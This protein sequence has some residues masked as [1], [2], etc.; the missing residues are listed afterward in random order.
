MNANRADLQRCA[1]KTV[2]GNPCRMRPLRGGR[3]CWTHDPEEATR[4]DAAR[5]R[6]GANRKRRG[7]VC[8]EFS[9][10]SIDGIADLLHLVVRDCLALDNSPRRCR[11]LLLVIPVAIKVLE[12]KA[13]LEQAAEAKARFG[14]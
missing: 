10:L 13:E 12:V 6:G 3:Y 7:S 8:P 2:G 1:A 4:R 14:L 5:R 9:L 11:V